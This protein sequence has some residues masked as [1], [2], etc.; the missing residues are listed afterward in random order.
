MWQT[1]IDFLVFLGWLWQ[2]TILILKDAFLPI[3]YIYTFL[4]QFFVF[5]FKPPTAFQT[6]WSFPTAIIDLF[7]SVPYFNVLVSAALVGITIIFVMFIL[8]TFLQ[9]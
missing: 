4:Y 5:A 2:N 7:Y 6:I 9:T 1:A 3:Q 8:K